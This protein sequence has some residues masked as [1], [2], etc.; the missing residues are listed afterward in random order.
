MSKEKPNLH[1]VPSGEEAISIA[2]PSAFNLDKFKS[3]RPATVAG[4]QQLQT[5]LPHH[6]IAAAKDFVRLHPDEDKY[7]SPELC[8]VNVPIKGVK[9]DTLHLID[10]DLAF[11]HV[12]SGKIQ[13]FR[14]VL[15]AKPHDIFFLCHVPSQNADNPWN[16]T[17]IKACETA[18]SSWVEATSRKAEGVE[19]YKIA[20]ARDA[21]AFPE[22]NWPKQTLNEL[23]QVTFVG[24]MIVTENDPGLL[25][26]VGAKQALS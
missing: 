15:A 25:R 10:E 4:V 2:K 9:H 17:N 1:A 12:P 24:R 16:A 23:I 13:R 18:K 6:N 19:A 21:D 11:Q 8:F 7:W 20:H 5:A 26:L 22:P 3:K 14:L